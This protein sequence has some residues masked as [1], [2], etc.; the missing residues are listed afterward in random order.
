[1]ATTR[2]AVRP[3]LTKAAPP[4]AEPLR[5]APQRFPIVGFGTSAGGLEA[6]ETFLH[7]RPADSGMGFVRAQH[8]DPSHASVPC[9]ILQRSTAMPVVEAEPMA[10]VQD[11]IKNLLD[12][13]RVELGGT[14]QASQGRSLFAIEAGRGDCAALHELLETVLPRERSFERRVVEHDCPGLGARRVQLG[15]RRIADPAGKDDLVPLAIDTLGT[16]PR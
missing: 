15:A 14:A 12:N 16:P 10:S 6:L 1:V 11:D 4:A 7:P 3:K 8:L 5:P 9:A 2:S 13:L